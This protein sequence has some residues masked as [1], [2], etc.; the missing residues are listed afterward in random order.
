VQLAIVPCSLG[1][2]RARIILSQLMLGF[3]YYSKEGVYQNYEFVRMDAIVAE[4]LTSSPRIFDIYGFCGYTVMSEFFPHGDMLDILVDGEGFSEP[5]D[6]N[7]KED[8][9]PQNNLTPIEKVQVSLNMAEAIADLHNYSGGVIVHGD[10]DPK[11]FLY[12]A[13]KSL[14]KLNDFNRAEWTLWDDE[15]QDYCRYPS[16]GGNGNVRIAASELLRLV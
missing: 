11:Q 7:D 12:N 5:E 13:D 14:I 6:M 3:R 1:L 16:G 8:V 15:K 10:I 9:N 2:V 4:R